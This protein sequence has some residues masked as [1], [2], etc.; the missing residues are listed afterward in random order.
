MRR[1]QGII[2]A[3]LYLMIFATSCGTNQF[4]IKLKTNSGTC[5]ESLLINS[6]LKSKSS[7]LE[8]R[9]AISLE[10]IQD[11]ALKTENLRKAIKNRKYVLQFFQREEEYDIS[12]PPVKFPLFWELDSL[13]VQT[14]GVFLIEIKGDNEVQIAFHCDECNQIDSNGNNVSP[15]KHDYQQEFQVKPNGN[16]SNADFS[17][18]LRPRKIPFS[19]AI[20]QR[21]LIKINSAESYCNS[22]KSRIHVE[23]TKDSAETFI[24]SYHDESEYWTS[25][26][27][28]ELAIAVAISDHEKTKNLFQEKIDSISL[29]IDTLKTKVKNLEQ[30]L[31]A[32]PNR[33]ERMAEFDEDENQLLILLESKVALQLEMAS[34]LPRILI[35]S[36]GTPSQKCD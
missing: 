6:P 28:K 25:L 33:N 12:I 29:E 17:I 20:G 11:E 30:L 22:A 34:M 2:G 15:K 7:I 1:F 36:S 35:L 14:E 5:L 3:I 32:L 4:E 31:E 21:F 19:D 13:S 24:L 23:K 10:L 16:I 27:I 8:T 9:E 26:F 18:R